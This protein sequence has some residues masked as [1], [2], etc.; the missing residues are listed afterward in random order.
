MARRVQVPP[1]MRSHIE[2]VTRPPTQ[3]VGGLVPQSPP[4]LLS[5]FRRIVRRLRPPT[6]LVRLRLTTILV[7]IIAVL[8]GVVVVLATCLAYA[9]EVPAPKPPEQPAVMHPRTTFPEP[10][11]VVLAPAE[12]APS[13][14]RR[15]AAVSAARS[16]RPSPVEGHTGI[17]V[18]IAMLVGLVVGR[19]TMR[20]GWCSPTATTPNRPAERL[21]SRRA[22]PHL[23]ATSIVG[24]V[25]E[26]NQDRVAVRVIAGQN[27]FVIADGV[28]GLARGGEA[29]EI[30]VTY[31]LKRLEAELPG[32]VAV[33]VDGVRALLLHIIWGAGVELARTAAE[34][35]WADE[36]EPGLRTTLLLAVVSCD[37]YVTAWIGDGGLF[38][39]RANDAIVPLLAPHKDPAVPDVLHASLGPATQGHPS[40]AIA[41]REPGDLFVGATDGIADVFNADLV[42]HIRLSLKDA[43]GNAALASSLVVDVLAAESTDT[44]A[45]RLTDNLT[46]ALLSDGAP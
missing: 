24:A 15:G 21:E 30:S 19:R 9:Q 5:F 33:G 11:P 39:V 1:A 25:R 10:P 37:R 29:A 20:E 34:S 23:G 4:V 44:G 22:A 36:D 38:V 13:T 26:T 46:L 42:E 14:M 2:Q 28:G 8:V 18:S 35:T 7:V 3:P 31:A 17:W 32:I 12:S 43:S 6:W 27:V 16:T 45:P 41:G 40:W